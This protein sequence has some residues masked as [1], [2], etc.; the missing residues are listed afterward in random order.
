MEKAKKDERPNKIVMTFRIAHDVA[1][2]LEAAR[3]N[4]KNKTA[5]IENAV[6]NTYFNLGGKDDGK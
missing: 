3:L 1:M 5:M 6:R 2:F 4:G